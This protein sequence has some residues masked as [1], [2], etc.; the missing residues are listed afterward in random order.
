[1]KV[2]DGL[3]DIRWIRGV[4]GER[5]LASSFALLPKL[6]KSLSVCHRRRIEIFLAC[7]LHCSTQMLFCQTPGQ[8]GLLVTDRFVNTVHGLA[9]EATS[10]RAAVNVPLLLCAGWHQH[11]DCA[12]LW[13][14]L[15]PGK[16]PCPASEAR[17]PVCPTWQT[18]WSWPLCSSSRV[19]DHKNTSL[20]WCV[21]AADRSLSCSPSTYHLDSI[22]KRQH[23]LLWRDSPM[24][25]F[26]LRTYHVW[27][28]FAI[29]D[30]GIKRTYVVFLDDYCGAT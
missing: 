29:S 5:L 18:K 7:V 26:A 14:L 9:M 15:K 21:L 27:R 19:G 24:S 1:M 30:T 11:T 25:I 8:R 28:K 10:I 4:R 13:L 16:T 17:V 12:V 22:K 20:C 23:N 6:N 2:N 3:E